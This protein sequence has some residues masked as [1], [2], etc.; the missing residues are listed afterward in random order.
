MIR[1]ICRRLAMA[2]LILTFISIVVFVMLRVGPGDPALVAQGLNATHEQIALVHAEMGLDDPYP[3]QYLNWL[4]SM[5][6][7]DFVRSILT[8]TAVAA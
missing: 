2:L 3:V 7:L 6:P 5:V 8:Q 1:Y 4:R